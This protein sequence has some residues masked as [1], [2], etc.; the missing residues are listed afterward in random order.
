MKTKRR[1][2]WK[3][4]KRRRRRQV[5]QP[6]RRA[7]PLHA[8]MP[9]NM[10]LSLKNAGAW[11]VTSRTRLASLSSAILLAVVCFQ[12][13]ISDNYYVY[14][15]SVAIQ[16]NQLNSQEAIYEASGL[17]GLNVFFVDTAAVRQS[18]AKLHGIRDVQVHIGL[19]NHVTIQVAEWQ[20]TVVWQAGDSRH[21]V[22]NMGTILP[23]TEATFTGTVTVVDMD[24][25]GLKPGDQVNPQAVQA[26]QSLQRLLPGV[27]TFNY[28]QK[29]GKG[30]SFQSSQ[31]W[32]VFIGSAEYLPEKILV[33][34]T[35]S[36]TLE[37]D[38]AKVAL[39]DVRYPSH[40][41]Y[42]EK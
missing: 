34:Q 22:D 2:W 31:G 19:S 36:R 7:R 5:S 14:R 32:Q 40:P 38:G 6:S 21:W 24:N 23:A 1:S 35:L 16:G 29:D 33:L 37:R 15:A 28:T 26:V 42:R 4:P 30:L 41:Y 13:G 18:I 8:A 39:V 11:W 17:E 25:R 9:L 20:P 3:W 27:N 12:F 10:R